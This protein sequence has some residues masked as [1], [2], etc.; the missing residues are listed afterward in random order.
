MTPAEAD[1]L[2]GMSP[3]A[4][5][6]TCASIRNK[7]RRIIQPV[8]NI[9]QLRMLAA[10][11]MCLATGRPPRIFGLKPRRVG[12]STIAAH[13]LY[14][15]ARRFPTMGVAIAD[16]NLKSAILYEMVT[17]YGDYD[18][19][20]WARPE[21]EYN[22]TRAMIGDDSEI[23]KRSAEAP[24]QTRGDTLQ[25]V[26]ASEVAWWRDV[27]PLSADETAV[28]LFNAL[29]DHEHTLG[30]LDTTPHGARGYAFEQWQSARWP[31]FDG[32]E[33]LFGYWRRYSVQNRDMD[34]S[35]LIR[36]FAAWF[37]FP[38]HCRPLDQAIDRERIMDTLTDRERA[39]IKKYQWSMEQIAWRRWA[40]R[41]KC[42]GDERRFD[43]EYPED[44]DMCWLSSGSPVFDAVGMSL[45][46]HAAGVAPTPL[47]FTWQP[48]G[49]VNRRL[50]STL[51][52]PIWEWEQ[53]AD[54][55][56]YLVICD[57]AESREVV[58]GTR[59]TDRH[60]VLVLRDAYKA[61]PGDYR[62]L[63]MVARVRPPCHLD[64]PML[65]EMIAFLS[66]Y[67]GHALTVVENNK[68]VGILRLLQDRY[69]VPLYRQKRL[70]MA[71]S[72]TVK[73]LG[74]RTDEKTR[75]LAVG[76][77][78]ELV[79]EQMIEI[80]DMWTVKE[81]STF[82]YNKEG[83]P[84]AGAGAH[85]DDVLALAI[86]AACMDSATPFARQYDEVMDAPDEGHW[87]EA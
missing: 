39:G 85:D 73:T 53:P 86:G 16:T 36:V 14:W 38:E 57:P 21:W 23:V 65:A 71:T 3:G 68:G 87:R 50:E 9:F 35:D 5:F 44:P 83:K 32:P 62:P 72:R 56:R 82:C 64:D 52:A 59:E 84:E 30:I 25:A 19:Y 70:D 43:E 24:R 13:I 51:D 17:L 33:N 48:G 37:E 18:G 80:P 42:L 4:H 49:G 41:N 58:S 76:M 8:P 66:V 6:M 78:Q 10:Y 7:A 45:L 29:A 54:G 40:I 15:H 77:L 81:M 11:E 20:Q 69:A 31:E 22:A 60:A 79:R 1:A 75:R 2:I 67:Y 26:L 28:S 74:W 55:M 12:G 34:A 27:G 61:G 63:K 46:T 47:S